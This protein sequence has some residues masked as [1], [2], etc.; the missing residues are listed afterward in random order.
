MLLYRSRNRQRETW[1]IY[2]ERRMKHNEWQWHNKTD[3][4]SRCRPN[5][6]TFN[7]FKMVRTSLHTQEIWESYTVSP[8]IC[9]LI[10]RINRREEWSQTIVDERLTGRPRVLGLFVFT[11]TGFT[12]K[13]KSVFM[14]ES[15]LVEY[16]LIVNRLTG[17]ARISSFRFRSGFDINCM[18][19]SSSCFLLWPL[20]R[21]KPR[22]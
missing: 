21:K 22:K 20:Q 14:P 17:G 10:Y 7:I 1:T 12:L 16:R 8:S 13:C 3:K 18:S 11:C 4:L 19:A 5:D 15:L 6:N 2:E 9:L